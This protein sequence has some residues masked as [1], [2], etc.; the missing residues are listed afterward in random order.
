MHI[1]SPRLF[2]S[3]TDTLTLSFTCQTRMLKE[4]KKDTPKAAVMSLL[5]I[6]KVSPYTLRA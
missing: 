2:A 6:K 5:V 1:H 4:E 3:H